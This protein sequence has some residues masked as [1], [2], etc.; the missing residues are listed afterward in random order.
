TS[1][2]DA[3]GERK[4][5]VEVR[6]P[7]GALRFETDEA[8]GAYRA[9]FSVLALV[10]DA[11]G[12]L[13]TQLSHDWPMSGPSSEVSRV[14]QQ[15]ANVRRELALAPGRYVLETAVLDRLGGLRS[16]QRTQLDVG[17]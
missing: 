10:R 9:H 11:A 2:A 4:T 16:T 13:V 12:A 17:S 15:S 8:Q 5:R 6:V 7:L 1:L 14:R 3:P